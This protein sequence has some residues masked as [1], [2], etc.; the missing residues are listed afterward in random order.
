MQEDSVR[1]FSSGLSLCF[2][3][4][5]TVNWV[6]HSDDFE[7]IELTLIQKYKPLLNIAKNPASLGILS[8]LRADCVRVANEN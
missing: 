8:D 3:N 1:V 6:S 2:H 5:L 7:N 4:N